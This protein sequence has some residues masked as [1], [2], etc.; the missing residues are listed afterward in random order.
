MKI[1]QTVIIYIFETGDTLL[2]DLRFE[3]VID[4]I[5]HVRVKKYIEIF[6]KVLSIRFK[7]IEK[8]RV[9]FPC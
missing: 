7:I 9:L 4:T 6:N 3:N 1:N 8:H 2:C 5:I